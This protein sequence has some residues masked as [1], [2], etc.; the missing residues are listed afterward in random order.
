VS[1]DVK[2]LTAPGDVRPPVPAELLDDPWF[3]FTGDVRVKALLDPVVPEPDRHDLPGACETCARPDED[4]IWTDARWR[5]HGFRQ[6][7]FP[8]TVLLMPRGHHDSYADLPDDLLREVG[9]LSARIERAI[10]GLG[11]IGRVHVC[12]YGDGGAHFHLWFLTRPLGALQLRGSM[13]TMWMDLV[14]TV[15]D[16][17]AQDAFDRIA[18]AL[19]AG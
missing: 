7:P 18:A 1:N 5:L 11:G 17:V 16:D 9:P 15:P 4:F 8:G 19:A 14:P 10:L 6:T 13:L 12:R 2:D 3:P